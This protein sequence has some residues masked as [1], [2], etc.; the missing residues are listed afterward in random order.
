MLKKAYRKIACH[1][2]IWEQDPMMIIDQTLFINMISMP[3][4]FKDTTQQWP[5]CLFYT[6]SYAHV[7]VYRE[8][9]CIVSKMAQIDLSV[10]MCHWTTNQSINFLWWQLIRPYIICIVLDWLNYL[11][12]TKL[13]WWL[14]ILSV[15][16]AYDAL[17]SFDVSEC[18]LCCH[19][20]CSIQKLPACE[21]SL[22]E[23]FRRLSFTA[24][25]LGHSR[26]LHMETLFLRCL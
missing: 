17:L 20:K 26:W 24:S 6:S 2:L 18:G 15:G 25:M 19:R 3:R 1:K 12:C 5:T 8:V 14:M 11:W 13:N 10:L 23:G 9:I 4:I 22:T 16:N 7:I 21:I